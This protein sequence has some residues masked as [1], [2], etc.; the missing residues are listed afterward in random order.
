MRI[1]GL[2]AEA[3]TELL[4]GVLQQARGELEAG[5]MVSVQESR[6][7]IRHLPLE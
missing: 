4:G 7:R 3:P 2:Q 6:I 1:E 5:A